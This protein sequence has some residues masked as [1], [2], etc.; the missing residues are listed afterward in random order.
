MFEHDTSSTALVLVDV[1][2]GLSFEGSEGIVQAATLAAPKIC[3]LRERAH[4][5]G[6]PVVYVNDNFGQWRSDLRAIIAACTAADQP[7]R[8]ITRMLVPTERDYFI[9]K[10]RHSAFYCTALEP[11]LQ[12]FGARRLVL[13]GFA[14]NICLLFSAN[15]AYMR[16][17]EVAVP[18]DCTA[19]NSPALVEQAL[20]QLRVAANARTD[21]SDELDLTALRD[22]G[23]PSS[24][25]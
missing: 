5:A 22:D 13:A 16:G 2:N 14:A 17:Y 21:A 3:A 11:L 4:R 24:R 19:A 18:A 8:D 9:L 25:T 23:E 20:A 7:G 10:P 1:I 12:S 15:D 6:V